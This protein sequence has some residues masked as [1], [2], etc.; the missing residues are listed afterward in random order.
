MA[1]QGEQSLDLFLYKWEALCSLRPTVDS[2]HGIT[3]Q[4]KHIAF[5]SF[6]SKIMFSFF[7]FPYHTG[8]QGRV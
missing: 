6:I 4:H 1:K 2:A 8:H 7:Q 5:T 3:R